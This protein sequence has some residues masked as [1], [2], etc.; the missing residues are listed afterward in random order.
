VRV[1]NRRF[2]S[3]VAVTGVLALMSAACVNAGGGD[4]EPT[5]EAAASV[6][7]TV[8]QEPTEPTTISFS[9][10]VGES[11]QMKKLAKQFNEV[12]PNITVEFENVPAGR[13]RD[14]LLTQVAGGNPPDVAYMD[15]GGVQDFASRGALVNLDGYIAGSDVVTEDDYVEGFRLSASFDDSMY[16]LP[17]DGETTGLFYR[18]DLFEAAGIDA[19]PETWEEFESAAQ[20]LTDPA[21]KQY[22]V[23][24]FATEAAYYWYPWLWQAGGNTLSEDG[25]TV[26][27]DDENGQQA[28]EFYVNLA[29][30]YAPPDYLAANSWD[31]R[32]AFATGK[33]GMYIAGNWFAGTLLSEFPDLEGKWASAP[34]P[35]GDAGCATTLAG[36]TLVMFDGSEDQD[37]AWL[38]MEFLSRPENMALW[39][40]ADETTTLL[41]PRQSLLES[42]EFTN[43]KPFLQGFAEDMG[44]AVVSTVEQPKW[45]EVETAL[46]EQLGAAMY[47]DLPVGEA[48]TTAAT[49]GQEILDS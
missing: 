9:S 44:C 15:A 36:D 29:Q 22:G 20:A 4:D 37:A 40:F 35:E 39:T 30:N 43:S 1:A 24:I 7:P 14:K 38:W 8:A 45:P 42:E 18:T 6:V 33:V 25:Q 10:W 21:S 49:E 5:E 16:G 19:P 47:G 3:I 11:P 12:Y 34:L 2:R 46:N 23:A 41:P 17:Y 26:A 32:V 27:F 31:G 28:A 48:L 13:S